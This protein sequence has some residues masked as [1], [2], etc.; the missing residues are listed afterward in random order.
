MVSLIKAPLFAS[1]R[2]FEQEITQQIIDSDPSAEIVWL[3]AGQQRFLGLFDEA[4]TKTVQGAVLILPGVG[5]HPQSEQLIAPLREQLQAFG[6]STLAIQLP[7]FRRVEY[8]KDTAPLVA[9]SQQRIQTALNILKEKKIENL[10]LLGHG[11]GATAALAFQSADANDDVRGL[12]LI[13]LPISIPDVQ[14]PST[15]DQLS[16]IKIPLMD[17]YG[18]AETP[19]VVANSNQRKWALKKNPTYRQVQINGVDHQF[20]GSTDLLVKTIYG[21][22]KKF[23]P[24]VEIK[25]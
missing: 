9:E 19:L 1:D 22:I 8:W 23:S 18:S 6:W 4:K 7:V 5:E 15:L 12:V 21:W 10:V 14:N 25:K 13:G 24:G 17:I 16:G 20:Q 2:L 3:N 11:L